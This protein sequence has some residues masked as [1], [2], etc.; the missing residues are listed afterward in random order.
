MFLYNLTPPTSPLPTAGRVTKRMKQS[1]VKQKWDCFVPRNDYVLTMGLLLSIPLLSKP[2]RSVRLVC[3]RHGFWRPKSNKKYFINKLLN[4][5]LNLKGG[6]NRLLFMKFIL[7]I[8]L[9]QLHQQ[10]AVPLLLIYRFLNSYNYP[11]HP[12]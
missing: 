11:S 4:K 8:E 7:I 1:Q 2:D 3:R 12:F 5:I 10:L 9:V 6:Q